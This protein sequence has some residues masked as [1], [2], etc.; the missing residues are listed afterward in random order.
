MAV[1]NYGR[2]LLAGLGLGSVCSC[3]H[4]ED[5][6]RGVLSSIEADFLQ[7]LP[8][9]LCL[10]HAATGPAIIVDDRPRSFSGAQ[11][12]SGS[13]GPGDGVLDLI[14]RIERVIVRPGDARGGD[15][16]QDA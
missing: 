2:R 14:P 5:G 8:G 6:R 7:R 15:G 16:D 10:V 1:S 11:C 13:R 12:S 3:Y 9:I 4:P